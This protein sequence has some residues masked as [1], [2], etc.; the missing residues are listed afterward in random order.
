MITR[1][2]PFDLLWQQENISNLRPG[3]QAAFNFVEFFRTLNFQKASILEGDFNAP[4]TIVNLADENRLRVGRV[5][6][7]TICL[8]VILIERIEA[9]GERHLLLFIEENILSIAI[10]IPGNKER[11]DHPP[12][13]RHHSAKKRNTFDD[14]IRTIQSSVK[15]IDI[16]NQVLTLSLQRCPKGELRNFIRASVKRLVDSYLIMITRCIPSFYCGNRKTI[17]ICDPGFKPH[18]T[19]WNF[20]EP[21]IFKGVHLAGDFNAPETIVGCIENHLVGG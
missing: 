21:L 11:I 19:S 8:R 1:C 14:Q 6:K 13:T 16:F 17:Q 9:L 7:G 2:V 12:K 4:E 15:R 10:N 20:S 5:R 18:L 3:F